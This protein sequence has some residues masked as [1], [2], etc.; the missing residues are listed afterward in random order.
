MSKYTILILPSAE[1]QIQKLPKEIRLI[2]TAAITNL[3]EEPRPAGCKKLKGVPAYRIRIGN[4]RVVYEIADRIL[5]VT[6]I[7][8]AHRK[9]IYK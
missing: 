8:A 4:Y 5:T 1:K 3:A 2:V 9:D 7:A 6:I